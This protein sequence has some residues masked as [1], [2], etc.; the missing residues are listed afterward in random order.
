[1]S[2]TARENDYLWG[3]LDGV[4]RLF[5]VLASTCGREVVAALDLRA[6]KKSAFEAVLAE[7]EVRLAKV[8]PLLARLRQTVAAL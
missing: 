1:L 2:R 7:E 6:F 5:D 3:R 8:A 4:D